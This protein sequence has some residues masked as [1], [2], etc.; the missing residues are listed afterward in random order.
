[1]CCRPLAVVPHNPRTYQ[2]GWAH[3]HTPILQPGRQSSRKHRPRPRYPENNVTLTHVRATAAPRASR[4]PACTHQDMRKPERCIDSGPS[5]LADPVICRL[6]TCTHVHTSKTCARDD[7]YATLRTVYSTQNNTPSRQHPLTPSKKR[8]ASSCM[9]LQSGRQMTQWHL[10][11]EP[12]LKFY[13]H[14]EETKSL[15]N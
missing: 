15:Y 12:L 2:L 9:I 4:L 8:A 13:E 7:I 10:L 6:Y 3:A 5:P 14:N 11:V 1:M